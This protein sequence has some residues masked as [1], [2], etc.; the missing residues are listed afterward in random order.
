MIPLS[1]K[2]KMA[3]IPTIGPYLLPLVARKLRKQLPNLKV[4]LYEYQTEPLLNRLREGEIELGILALPVHL[5]WTGHPRAVSRAIHGGGS[6][7]ASTRE[8]IQLSGSM[9]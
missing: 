4:M 6:E 7:S 9:I 5:R 2:L 1:G 8:E 3:L